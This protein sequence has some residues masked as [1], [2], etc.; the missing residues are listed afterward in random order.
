MRDQKPE[1]RKKIAD[2]KDFDN[3]AM[4]ATGKAIQEFQ[5][6]YSAK[7]ERGATARV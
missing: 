7:N 2:T 5:S 3:D 4:A 1:I 6:Q